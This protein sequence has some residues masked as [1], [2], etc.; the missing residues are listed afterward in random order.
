MEKQL[1][2]KKEISEVPRFNINNVR[3]FNQIGSGAYGCVRLCVNIEKV[4]KENVPVV[5]KASSL[6]MS[7]ISIP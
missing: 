4:D 6:T 2:V 1:Q 7:N 3:F 5:K